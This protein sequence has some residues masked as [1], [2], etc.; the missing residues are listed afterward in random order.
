MRWE[1]AVPSLG[2]ELPALP[3]FFG[4]A[5]PQK[6]G[7][8]RALQRLSH[9][10]PCPSAA[11]ACSPAPCP[12]P[13]M[14]AAA[15]YLLSGPARPQLPALPGP[16]PSSP[17]EAAPA[18]LGACC[19]GRGRA[20]AVGRWLPGCGGLGLGSNAASLLGGSGAW[21]PRAARLPARVPTSLCIS[22]FNK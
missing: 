6:V 8:L 11:R 15:P 9:S 20:L 18:P 21:P 3:R 1:G 2:G 13:A 19:R 12:R 14:A 5:T 4:G 16:G 7:S 17:G 22:I 10:A